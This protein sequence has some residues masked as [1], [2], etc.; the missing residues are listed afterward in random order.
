MA[1]ALK[2]KKISPTDRCTLAAVRILRTRLKEFYSHWRDSAQ[3]P[4]PTQLHNLR[5]SGKRLRYSAESLQALYPDRLALLIDLLKRLQDV[6]GEIQDCQIQSAI[7]EASLARRGRYHPSAAE[8]VVLEG[9]IQRDQ[10][11]QAKLFAELANLWRGIASKK[12]HESLKDLVSHPIEPRLESEELI[13]P[14]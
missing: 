4:T 6:L 10:Q 1:K 5:I 13:T 3:I 7:I 11:R 2:V 12:F 8:T 14:D 9:L